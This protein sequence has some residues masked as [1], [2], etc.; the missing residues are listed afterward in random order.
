MFGR[1]RRQRIA[2]GK[3]SDLSWRACR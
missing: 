2:T 1:N 3:R